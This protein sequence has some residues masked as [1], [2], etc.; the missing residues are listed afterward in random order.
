MESFKMLEALSN[1]ED[2]ITGIPSGF[3][4]LDEMTGGWQR[5]DLV[6]IA[7]RPSMGK[8]ALSL[9]VARNA[10]LHAEYATPVSPTSRSK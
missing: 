4:R 5:S 9:A 10:A 8:T 7:A 6:I 1:R 2:G 3:H